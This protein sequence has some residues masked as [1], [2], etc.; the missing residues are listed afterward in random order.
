METFLFGSGFALI[1]ALLSWSDRIKDLQ[2]ETQ[3][4]KQYLRKN[5][6]PIY[7]KISIISSQQEAISLDKRIES[8]TSFMK[9]SFTES[10]IENTLAN[11]TKFMNVFDL[12]FKL[13]S[14]LQRK[15]KLIVFLAF[16]LIIS[17]L[18]AIFIPNQ[19]HF[20]ISGNK[21]LVDYILIVPIIPY[22]L[23]LLFYLLFINKKESVYQKELS[24]TMELF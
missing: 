9:K 4:L 18:I 3:E 20:Q 10:E 8:L 19:N 16:Y 15:F 1:I 21:I 13:K 7:T 17:G 6:E 5:K 11:I 22:C 2:R 23:F 12:G 14:Y 24:E